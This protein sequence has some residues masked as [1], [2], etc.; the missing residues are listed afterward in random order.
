RI[1]GG[2]STYY[3]LLQHAFN[4][5]GNGT[6]IKITTTPLSEN[7]VLSNSGSI[8]IRGGYDSGLGSVTGRTQVSGSL[9]TQAGT[10]TI[11]NLD[12]LGNVTINGGTVVAGS[13][14]IL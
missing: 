5:A 7:L 1:E 11:E 12:Q 6:L 2:S 4:A 9:T 3:S 8:T 10:L 13:L 14:S